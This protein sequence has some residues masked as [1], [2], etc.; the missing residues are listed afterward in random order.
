MP[1]FD[2]VSYEDLLKHLQEERGLSEKT[3]IVALAKTTARAR[4]ELLEKLRGKFDL[5]PAWHDMLTRVISSA[6]NAETGEAGL[7][8]WFFLDQVERDLEEKGPSQ[9]LFERMQEF[10]HSSMGGWQSGPMGLSGTAF[11]IPEDKV[12]NCRGLDVGTTN[13]LGA[14]RRQDNNEDV[15][16]GQRNA[17]LDVR[18]DAFTE[19]MLKKLGIDHVSFRGKGFVIGDAAFELANIFQRDTRHTMKEGLI[20]SDEE[21]SLTMIGLVIQKVIGKPLNENVPCAYSIPAD[22]IDSHKSAVYHRGAVEMVLR[23]MGY[24]PKPVIE[25]HAIV[26]A[27][28][29]EEEFTGIGISCGG[30][31]FNA[32]LAY[33]ALPAITFSTS[34]GGDWIDNNVAESLGIPASQVCAI[35]EGGVNLSNPTGRV[36]EAICIYFRDL[37]RYTLDTFT[38]R[39][40]SADDVPTFTR[41]VELV[42]SG[43]TALI[44]GFTEIFAQEMERARL[45]IEIDRVRLASDPLRTVARG[46]LYAA[47]EK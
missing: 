35:K 25:G 43:G 30:G 22:P 5:S 15:Y 18:S 8:H 13:V 6:D 47:L 3:A 38:K 32:C 31:M 10:L 19:R 23:K 45:P 27:E 24:I 39:F 26:L 17:F 7:L 9:A 41:P 21:N 29:E 11:H 46:C 33:K 42:L 12:V 34:R 40:S 4:R 28:L 37:V 16:Y 2:E 44:K 1:S 14:V 20:S 36:E